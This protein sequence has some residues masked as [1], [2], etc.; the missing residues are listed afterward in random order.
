[1]E[2]VNLVKF[3]LLVVKQYYR[4]L[5]DA[6][7]P[8]AKYR[9]L[10]DRYDKAASSLDPVL[11]RL[12]LVMYHKGATFQGVSDVF[13]CSRRTVYRYHD[14]LLSSLAALLPCS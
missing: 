2:N 5:V 14:A 1:M 4:F 10:V 6:D 8:G 12:Y 13:N 7:V 3:E 11:F 9:D